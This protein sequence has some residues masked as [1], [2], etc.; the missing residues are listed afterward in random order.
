MA[1]FVLNP[2]TG[3]L[4]FG[5]GNSKGLQLHTNI[6][7]EVTQRINQ[8]L[9][10]NIGEWFADVSKGLPYI[11]NNQESV[12]DNLRYLLGDHN[13]DVTNFIFKTLN[14]Y[15]EN[16]PMVSK[17]NSSSFTLDSSGRVF[18]YELKVTI[19]NEEIITFPSII[20]SI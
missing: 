19:E 2:L 8:A 10:L 15:I 1:D 14:N 13:P 18:N 9:G 11:K 6:G 7:D 5:E 17:L 16:L 12:G 20:I 3:D 4:A